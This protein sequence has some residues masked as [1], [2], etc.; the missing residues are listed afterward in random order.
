MSGNNAT[1]FNLPIDLALDSSNSIY[2]TDYYNNRIQKWISGESFGRTVAGQTDGS[3]SNATS[4]LFHPDGVYVDSNENIYAS[5][6]GNNRI[7]LWMKGATNGTYVA[8]TGRKPFSYK[9]STIHRIDLYVLGVQGSANNQLNSPYGI[10]K[11][12]ITNKLYIADFYNNRVMGYPSGVL[13]GSIEAGGNGQGFSS[14]QLNNP[15]GIYLDSI[16]NSL[17]IANFQSNNIVRWP[18]AA[19][20]WTLVAGNLTG[21]GGS[22]STMLNLCAGV[23]LDP[24]SNVY[25]ADSGNQR[26]QFFSQGQMEGR[27]IAGVT[28]TTS[29]ASNH[30]SIPYNVRLDHQLN[31]YVV[32]SG[33]NRI[34]KFE[35]Y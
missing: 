17:F 13:T 10:T 21:A 15:V 35:R 7:M 9:W 12:P 6:T 28:G 23:T 8:G 32:D 25:V 16:T 29:T 26:I 19:T 20:N 2:V 24:M 22:S 4:H 1:E 5:D 18:L 31:L 33:N 11:D 14:M 27:T 3:A 30:L 34:Q